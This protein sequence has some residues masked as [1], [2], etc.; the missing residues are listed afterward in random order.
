MHW[1]DSPIRSP[2]NNLADMSIAYLGKCLKFYI[3]SEFTVKDF[4][5]FVNKAIL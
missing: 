1:K 5:Y 4:R 2:N 3:K